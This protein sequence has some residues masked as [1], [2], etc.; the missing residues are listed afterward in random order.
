MR[1][2]RI[3]YLFLLAAAVT[4]LLGCLTLWVYLPW[5]GK[6]SKQIAVALLEYRNLTATNGLGALGTELPS[7]LM[8]YHNWNPS[9]ESGPDFAETGYYYHQFGFYFERSFDLKRDLPDGN[10]WTLT[11]TVRACPPM[12]QHEFWRT[13]RLLT[14]TDGAAR[15]GQNKSIPSDAVIRKNMPGIW[16][17]TVFAS[18]NGWMKKVV[19]APSGNYSGID[20]FAG[21]VEEDKEFGRIQIENGF[22][23]QTLT[24]TEPRVP[25]LPSTNRL[26]IIYADDHK[27]C[28]LHDP[29]PGKLLLEKQAE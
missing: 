25:R 4:L 12:T 7:S 20:L 2:R 18:P 5:S 21:K 24:N 14:I 9:R 27:M 19:I 15:A 11:T 23:I 6:S 26:Q 8:L 13:Q 17:M 29:F 16:R 1:F 3:R 28:I 22:W 10:T